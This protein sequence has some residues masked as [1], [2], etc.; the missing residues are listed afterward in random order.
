MGRIM[1]M[2]RTPRVRGW[3]QETLGEA[4]KNRLRLNG[5]GEVGNVVMTRLE[6]T[7]VDRGGAQLFLNA[8]ELVVFGDA[9][10]AGG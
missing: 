8:E 7:G 5:A 4:Q 2:T 1:M 6:A 9:V 10:S 3:L